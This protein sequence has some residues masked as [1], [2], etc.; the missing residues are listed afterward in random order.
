MFFKNGLPYSPDFDDIYFSTGAEN[1]TK[2]VFIRGNNL[3]ERW[4]LPEKIVIGELGFGTG[5][6]FYITSQEFLKTAHTQSRLFYIS[7]EKFP[8]GVQEMRLFW[9]TLG[10][11]PE[12]LSYWPGKR[13]TGG[14]LRLVFSDGRITLDLLFDEATIAWNNFSGQIHAWYLDGFSP[15][16][17]PDMWSATLFRIL[18]KKSVPNATFATYSSAGMVKRNL[19]AAGWSYTKIQGAGNKRHMLVGSVMPGRSTSTALVKLTTAK[20]IA[21]IGAGIAGSALAYTLR[22]RGAQVTV[23]ERENSAAQKASGNKAGLV[24]PHFFREH[25]IRGKFLMIAYNYFKSFFEQNSD[26]KKQD[27]VTELNGSVTHTFSYDEI[28]NS[29]FSE[30]LTA[31]DESSIH[32]LLGCFLIKPVL[33]CE[34]LLK[35]SKAERIFSAGETQII[36]QA[37]SVLVQAAYP[38]KTREFDTV[39]SACGADTKG[40]EKFFTI[41]RKRGAVIELQNHDLPAS[42][43]FSGDFYYGILKDVAVA[44]A[45]Y[46]DKELNNEERKNLI[47]Q[48]LKEKMPETIAEKFYKQG[49]IRVSDRATVRDFMPVTG[50]I[51]E[52]NF[53]YML[54]GLGSHGLMTALLCAESLSAE[55]F[56]EPDILPENLRD[57]VAVNRFILRDTK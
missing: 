16:K 7:C 47:L 18:R 57:A 25:D 15:A 5:L 22:A 40:F 9:D 21:I 12:F 55:I 20:R 19:T 31:D 14:R 46:E 45:T 32:T 24:I 29:G 41:T 51:P 4:S 37:D 56:A 38:P 33:F 42:Q 48:S 43:I 54:T 53:L 39:I 1:E 52:N 35:Q 11:K 26:L 3:Y 23:Y 27:I 34:W 49:N 10:E 8:L 30:Y 6:N 13:H 2:H 17:N 28:K 44:G 50:A 36:P